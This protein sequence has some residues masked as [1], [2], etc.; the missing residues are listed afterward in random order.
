MQ[1]WC[2]LITIY[3]DVLYVPR[4]QQSIA[5]LVCSGYIPNNLCRNSK[6]AS[7]TLAVYPYDERAIMHVFEALHWSLYPAGHEY[8]VFGGTKRGRP[9]PEA[10]SRIL[11]TCEVTGGTMVR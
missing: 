7:H 9:V 1:F 3:Y 8:V 10:H 6:R 5:T 2:R 11:H 4:V